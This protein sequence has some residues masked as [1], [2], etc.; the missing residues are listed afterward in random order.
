[1]PLV[2][3]QDLVKAAAQTTERLFGSSVS[4]RVYA[5]VESLDVF[6]QVISVTLPAH[7]IA[8]SSSFSLGA[9]CSQQ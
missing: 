4:N 8:P 9:A 6:V 7:L 2:A 1:M 5:A 3:A